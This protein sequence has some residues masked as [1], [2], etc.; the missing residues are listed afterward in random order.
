MNPTVPELLGQGL[1]I[2]AVGMGLVF[3]ALALLWGLIRGLGAIFAEHDEREAAPVIV[4]LQASATV[5]PRAELDAAAQA[6]LLTAE[7]ARVA[8]V[9]AGALLANALP[10]L[11][12]VPT[13]PAFE[14]GRTAPS[15]VTSNRARALHSW[16]PPRASESGSP[17]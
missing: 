6:E 16:Q 1:L 8:A 10:L 14:H 2:T 12:E 15:W 5:T 9:V 4:P 11:F 3:G 13:G 17:H 7:R